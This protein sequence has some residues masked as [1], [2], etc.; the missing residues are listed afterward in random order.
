M[1]TTS[2]KLG[3]IDKV[4][5]IALIIFTLV[6]VAITNI[7]PAEAHVYWLVMNLVFA[8]GAIITGWHKAQTKKEHT[9]LI[10]SQLIHWVSTMVAVMI[11]YAFLHSGQIQNETVSLAIVLILSLSTFLAGIHIGWQFSVVG[12]LLAISVLIISY[13]EEYIWL[14]VIIALALVLISYFWNKF[15]KS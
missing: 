6:G 14:I 15:K 5:F 10:T 11:V 12:I 9:K 2:S 1:S 7:S 3:I 4:I 13:V 8:I